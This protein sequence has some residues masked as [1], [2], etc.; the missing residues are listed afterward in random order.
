MVY[1][2]NK[3]IAI[4]TENEPASRSLE[5]SPG[6]RERND[7]KMWQNAVFLKYSVLTLT[8]LAACAAKKLSNGQ[9]KWD[10]AALL[11]LPVLREKYP[12]NEAFQKAAWLQNNEEEA[13]LRPMKPTQQ[14]NKRLYRKAKRGNKGWVFRV[15]PQVGSWFVF[16]RL[17][18]KHSW[19]WKSLNPIMSFND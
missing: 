13:C 16:H 12:A 1:L 17:L 2:E 11:L 4:K 19:K 8:N 10:L 18:V 14:N 5:W 7:N 6:I 15:F 9:K 3:T